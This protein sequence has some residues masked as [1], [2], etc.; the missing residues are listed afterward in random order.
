MHWGTSCI[1]IHPRGNPDTIIADISCVFRLVIAR[2]LTV[3]VRAPQEAQRGPPVQIPRGP[4][5]QPEER[6]WAILPVAPRPVPLPHRSPPLSP[7]APPASPSHPLAP[8]PARP[9]PRSDPPPARNPVVKRLARELIPVNLRT[10]KLF[11]QFL[12]SKVLTKMEVACP[13]WKPRSSLIWHINH[14]VISV[15]KSYLI[16]KLVEVY[17][18]QSTKCISN[19]YNF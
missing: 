6:P 13:G 9:A 16:K 1:P 8:S 11:L 17:G 7:G 15:R 2:E 19:H 10:I 4:S 5:N 3:E 12:G 14:M 18:V